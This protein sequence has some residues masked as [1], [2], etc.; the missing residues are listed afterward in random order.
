M[1]AEGTRIADRYDGELSRSLK[2]FTT[3]LEPL[4]ML[5]IAVLVGFIVASMLLAV[6]SLSSGFDK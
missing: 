4:M 6:M 1:T 5:F 2:A 3:I